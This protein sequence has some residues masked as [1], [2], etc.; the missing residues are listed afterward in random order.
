MQ[1]NY[2]LSSKRVGC[3]IIRAHSGVRPLSAQPAVS[4]SWELNVKFMV[5]QISENPYTLPSSHYKL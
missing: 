3:R 2:G 4:T 1:T 5:Q